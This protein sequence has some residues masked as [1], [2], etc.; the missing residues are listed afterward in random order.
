MKRPCMN[1]TRRVKC[2]LAAWFMAV[3]ADG[4]GEISY[5]VD[6]YDSW[7]KLLEEKEVSGG[8]REGL[9]QFAF[10][11]GSA[12]LKNEEGNASYSPL[13]LYYA[14]AL[15]GC[16]AEGG[17]AAQI[18][19]N[20]GVENREELA[21]QCQKLYEWY[22][23][24]EQWDK[25]RMEKY[26]EGGFD[27]TIRLANSLWISEH[28]DVRKEYQ[29]MA[30]EQFFASSYGVDF[31]DPATGKRMGEW[32]AEKTN[33]VMEP[34][35]ETDPDILLSIVNT[36]YFY[37]GWVNPF[38]EDSTAEDKFTLEDGSQ[39]VCPFLN[40]VNRQG[41]FKRGEG[42]TLSY[43]DTNNHCR[44]VFLLPDEGRQVSE[45]LE[46]PELMRAA[47]DMDSEDWTNGEV[48][49]KV[50][51]FAF[52]SSFKLEEILKAMGMERMFGDE[53]EFGGIS[54]QDLFVSSVIQETHIGLDEQGVEGAAYTMIAMKGNAMMEPQ[55]RA[56]MILDR[57]FL[58][59][60]Q[61]MNQGAWL[62][63]GVCRNPAG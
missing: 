10:N 51:R 14:L 28:L 47:M 25:K 32:I 23:C 45:F 2:L 54:P 27:S 15:A 9:K 26:G 8:F 34:Q 57:P 33:G 44:M 41:R 16:G 43:L 3:S 58:F 1:L 21:D 55:A 12:V 35:I 30:K 5:D 61:D 4:P 49:W 6:D 62:F 38:S 56:D 13:S 46:T 37:G 50:P 19:Q 39:I 20:L 59:G 7:N 11:S 60:I 63:L 17:T 40:Q 24:R 36:L 22:D 42:C 18:Y 29:E 52:G 31:A 53:A 48:T